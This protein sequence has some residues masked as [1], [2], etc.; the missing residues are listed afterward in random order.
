VD[1]PFLQALN[2]ATASATSTTI[3]RLRTALGFVALANTD[4]ELMDDAADA[5]LMGSAFEQL[6]EEGEGKARK[7]TTA[8]GELFIGCGSITVETTQ[9]TAA[10]SGIKV[11]TSKPEYEAAQK[12][13]WMH[14]VWMRELYALR[15]DYVHERHAA[16]N[17]GWSPPQ[18]LVMA[19]FVF[20]ITVKKLLAPEGFYTLTEGDEVRCVSMDKLLL[21]DSWRWHDDQTGWNQILNQERPGRSR[22]R[23]AQKL[24]DLFSQ[25]SGE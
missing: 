20:P 5:I 1:E 9:A 10:H 24:C 7:L 22:K 21:A 12:K 17:K 25:G 4:D 3:D 14:K 6:F 19:A 2:T 8:F 11:V 15:S 18:H 23:L 13:W 16:G